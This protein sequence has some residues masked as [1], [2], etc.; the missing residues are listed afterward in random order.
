MSA[1]VTIPSPPAPR[2]R[3]SLGIT[4]HR[5]GNAAFNANR[6]R[7]EIVLSEIFDLISA[8]IAAEPASSGGEVAP[9]RLHTLLSE[10]ADQ[11]AAENA[12]ARGW[13][14]V[15]PLPFGLN[16]NVAI[17]ALPVTADDA[18]ALLEGKPPRSVDVG[19]RAARIREI[20]A[21]A[22]LF[23][24]ADR[25]DVIAG[26]FIAG[27]Q[28]PDDPSRSS[29]FAAEASLRAALAAKVMIEQ[30]DLIIAI[31]DGVSRAFTGGTGHT[32]QIALETGAPVVW[33]DSNA[34][35]KWRILYGPEALASVHVHPGP[36]AN[37]TSEL[38][39]LVRAALRPAVSRKAVHGEPAGHGAQDNERWHAHSN[40]LWHGYRR[41]EALFGADTMKARFKHLRQTYEPPDA[42]ATGSA[43]GLLADA[44]ALPGQEESFVASIEAGV[45]RRFAWSDG[46]SARLSD[47]YRGGMVA[48]FLLAPMAIVG[49]I[50]YLPFASSASKWM[51]ALGELMLLASI[52]AITIVG[53]QRRW[54]GR[55]FE[56]RRV[57]EYFRHAPILLLLGVARP[58]GRWPKGAE[59]SWPEWY[60]RRGLRDVGLPQ[61]VMT[62]AYLRKA[63]A[64]LLDTHV[65]RQ[66][67]YHLYKAKRLTAAHLNLDKLSELMFTL[68]VISVAFYLV[69]KGGGVMHWWPKKIS[70]EYSYLFTFLGVLLP[71]FGG[72][73]AG[74]RYFG[75][76]E[77]FSAISEV[78]A[79]KLT[80]V[81]ARIAQLLA[82]PDSTLDYGQVA[83]LAHAADDIVVS[84][85][86]SWQAVFGGKHVTVPV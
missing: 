39:G 2:V 14:L 21:R 77:R 37:R 61:L 63:L 68:A 42:I 38:Q 13:E 59:T 72:T 41:V 58:P 45:L 71:T 79:E 54:H 7:I 64:D 24:L 28:Y 23:E 31:W 15:A 52:L 20:A 9:T 53:Q 65:V 11:M 6:G 75:D 5:E 81:H 84:E 33:M 66:R 78:T 73:I 26:L 34:P 48:N 49:G 83:D 74:I 4:G 56:T 35:D 67:D 82:T 3:L 69:L 19:K 80:A 57:A 32:V 17:N 27:L 62:Q 44:R 16:L 25:D 70:E 85:I 60:A 10:G 76:F 47:I 46:I 29:T 86:E 18:R 8:A 36:D 22:R 1:V 40:P 51:F 55:W 50:A 30:S 12:L 43:A